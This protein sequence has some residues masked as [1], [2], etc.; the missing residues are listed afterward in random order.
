[1][2]IRVRA[3][4]IICGLVRRLRADPYR[5]NLFLGTCIG[6]VAAVCHLPL[7]VALLVSV[8]VGWFFP[9]GEEVATDEA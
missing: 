8:T 5:A 3:R 4:V 7:W 1:M 6:Q 9:L 2:N